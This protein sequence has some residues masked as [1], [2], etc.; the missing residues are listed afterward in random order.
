M[1]MWSVIC[2]IAFHLPSFVAFRNKCPCPSERNFRATALCNTSLALNYS[3]LFD[4]N[5]GFNVESCITKTDFAPPGYK[6]LLRGQPDFTQ[7]EIERY[8]PIRLLSNVS[9]QCIFEKSKCIENGQFLFKN[10]T[11]ETDRSCRCDYTRGYAFIT[12]PKNL[13]SCIPSEEDCNCY[14][15]SC[16][17]RGLLTPDYECATEKDKP[18]QNTY[19]CPIIVYKRLQTDSFIIKEKEILLKEQGMGKFFNYQLPTT[20]K[21]MK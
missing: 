2:L 18:G 12:K 11:T 10:G 3:C 4:E 20:I 14:K 1:K 8:Q 17:H 7:C 21:H 6:Y 19:F 5:R 9:N 16:P 15:K 13:C